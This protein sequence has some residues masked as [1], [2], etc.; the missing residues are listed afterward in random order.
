MSEIRSK[1][2]NA[3]NML[4]IKTEDMMSTNPQQKQ[5][6][7]KQIKVPIKN[8][9]KDIYSKY[10]TPILIYVII[11]LNKN[12]NNNNNN[13]TS[14]T[15]TNNNDDDDDD[16][17]NRSSASG[18]SRYQEY[19]QNA[20]NE[21]HQ[22]TSSIIQSTQNKYHFNRNFTRN[23]YVQ[24]LGYYKSDFH[25]RHGFFSGLNW[26]LRA[27]SRQHEELLCLASRSYIMKKIHSRMIS[28]LQLNVII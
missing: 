2:E 24:P 20:V 19:I 3:W 26:I 9:I 8:E 16:D 15:T 18:T 10:N 17:N 21:V 7:Q 13:N 5:K 25:L 4:H 1:L 6:Q 12:N 27:C 22:I 23:W 14:T 11:E 28:K